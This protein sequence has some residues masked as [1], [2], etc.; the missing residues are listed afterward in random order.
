MTPLD[1]EKLLWTCAIT[2]GD[3]MVEWAW[4]KNEKKKEKNCRS[5]TK[6]LDYHILVPHY[7]YRYYNKC[8]WIHTLHHFG[9]F[10]SKILIT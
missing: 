6:W 7:R 1:I 9:R 4:N 2:G 5:L 3:M 8:K 10:L